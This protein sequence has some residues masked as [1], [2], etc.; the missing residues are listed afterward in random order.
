MAELSTLPKAGGGR[1]ALCV[2]AAKAS[3]LSGGFVNGTTSVRSSPLE[4]L[5]S[6]LSVVPVV[7]RRG[8]FLTGNVSC[9]DFVRTVE[10]AVGAI[11]R[12]GVRAGA[13]AVDFADFCGLVCGLIFGVLCCN[14]VRR[15]AAYGSAVA[16]L[17]TS[18]LRGLRTGAAISELPADA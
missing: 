18:G 16:G 8:V 17:A 7:L 12:P 9:R 10:L 11:A 5:E 3:S 4:G 15:L 14:P 1:G 13:F 2:G 6:G